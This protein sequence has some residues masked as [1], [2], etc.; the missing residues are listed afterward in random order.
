VLSTYICILKE[1]SQISTS[2]IASI[3][4]TKLKGDS[5][6][7]DY[8]V[9]L[10]AYNISN[11][12]S[13]HFPFASSSLL[14]SSINITLLAASSCPLVCRCST[15]LVICLIPRL[16]LNLTNSLSMNYRPLSVMIVCGTPY[17]H[18]MFF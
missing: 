17:W 5:L 4:Y 8:G 11:N 6:V 14:H 16:V 1:G 13:S 9:H 3:L 18:I 2:I 7:A 12:S 10:Y 15:E